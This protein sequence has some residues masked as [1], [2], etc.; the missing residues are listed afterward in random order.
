MRIYSAPRAVS[1]KSPRERVSPEGFSNAPSSTDGIADFDLGAVPEQP[2]HMTKRTSRAA[3]IA[4]RA[5]CGNAGKTKGF[6]DR[7][8]RG[9]QGIISLFRIVQSSGADNSTTGVL[10]RKA[11]LVY[12]VKVIP[13]DSL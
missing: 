2:K 12:S 6:P 4:I 1:R 8:E 13:F 11:G 10:I 5:A 7:E 9:V 3:G